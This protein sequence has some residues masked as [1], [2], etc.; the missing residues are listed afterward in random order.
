MVEI[1]MFVRV[2]N[3]YSSKYSV[4]I[5]IRQGSVLGPNLFILFINNMLEH[6]NIYNLLKLISFA[7]GT[8]IAV[9]T[10]N[11]N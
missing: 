5:G 7:D 2:G 11:I 9:A 8:S 1:P 3:S 10:R 6:F 4:D